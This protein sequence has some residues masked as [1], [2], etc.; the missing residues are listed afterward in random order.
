MIYNNPIESILTEWIYNAAARNKTQLVKDYWLLR[1][2]ATG[3]MS[4]MFYITNA[5]RKNKI[6]QEL[7]M[8]LMDAQKIIDA[9]KDLPVDPFAISNNEAKIQKELF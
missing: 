2:Y 6:L 3:D 4:D 9:L 1:Y 7:D 8:K 5:S